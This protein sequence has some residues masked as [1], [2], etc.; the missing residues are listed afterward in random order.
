M[1]TER[2]DRNAGVPTEQSI[3]LGWRALWVR[4]RK[5][6]RLEERAGREPHIPGMGEQSVLWKQASPTVTPH[7]QPAPAS[8]ADPSPGRTRCSL[9]L[10]VGF[11]GRKPKMFGITAL[12][13]RPTSGIAQTVRREG[14]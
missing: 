7:P 1:V 4:Q 10:S 5:G 8:W 13:P 2:G 9:I 12:T 14:R 6:A 11:Q 3:L